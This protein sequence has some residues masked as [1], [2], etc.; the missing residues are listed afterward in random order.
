[1]SEL[2]KQFSWHSGMTWGYIICLFFFGQLLLWFDRYIHEPSQ[3]SIP[4]SW[5]LTL[6]GG[7]WPR[8]SETLK[9]G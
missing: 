5:V 2:G 6:A 9:Q 1:M 7:S 4:F 8:A 3:S